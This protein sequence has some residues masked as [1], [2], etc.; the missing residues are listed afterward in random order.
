VAIEYVEAFVVDR[1][2][3]RRHCI[4]RHNPALEETVR[5]VGVARERFEGNQ[6][7]KH[8]QVQPATSGERAGLRCCIDHHCDVSFYPYCYGHSPG[9]L[10]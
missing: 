9:P 6:I 4:P 10:D 8:I 1:V 5:A 2:V 3:V 7:A